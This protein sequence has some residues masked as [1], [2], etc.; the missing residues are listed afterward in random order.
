MSKTP[1]WK[2]K[3]GEYYVLVQVL[4]ILL[5]FL[6]PRSSLT[7]PSWMNPYMQIISFAGGLL[8]F[9]GAILLLFS[10]LKMGANLTPV[11]YPR[12][13]A[14]LLET[15]P[16]KYV[17]HPMYSGGLLMSFGWAL[18]I[19]SPLTICYAVIMF[20]FFDIKS[21]REEQWLSEK[22]AGYAEYIKRVRKLIPFIY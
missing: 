6:G 8:I 3:R 13:Q 19:Q 11:P 21:R 2:G 14:K 1:W 15:G 5:V 7:P 12:E 20:I 16:Y 9:S 18:F 17:R 4:L 10:I 22:F